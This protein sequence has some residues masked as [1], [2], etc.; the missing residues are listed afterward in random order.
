MGLKRKSGR[1]VFRSSKITESP[2]VEAT[3][4]TKCQS[5]GGCKKVNMY[6]Q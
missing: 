6:L 1:K 2:V 5:F 3:M 4:T